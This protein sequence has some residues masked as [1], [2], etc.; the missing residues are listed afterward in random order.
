MPLAWLF[1]KALNRSRAIGLENL[2]KE[3]GALLASNH[4]SGVDTM[5]IP[6]FA[7]SKRPF[8]TPAKEELFKVPVMGPILKFWGAFP[9]KRHSRDVESMKRIAVSARKYMV[10]IFPEGTRTKTG[11]LLKGRPGVG[12]IAYSAHPVVIPTLVINTDKFFW[13]GRPRPWFGVPYTVVF[14][15]PVDLSRFYD[16]PDTKETSQA[17]VD[18][19]MDKIGELKKKHSDIY[20]NPVL[21]P[22]GS[23][24]GQLIDGVVK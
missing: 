12:W 17:I 15:E 6:Y 2:P 7:Y 18:E 8:I 5:L 10:M 4:V 9:V 14:G 19:I 11:N 16:L 3:G 21:L 24:A 13:P 22:D 1:Y 23:P 20:L